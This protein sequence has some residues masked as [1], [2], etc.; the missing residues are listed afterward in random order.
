MAE[1]YRQDGKTEQALD[2]YN[3]AAKDKNYA[4]S[5]LQRMS[6]LYAL[7]KQP[8]AAVKAARRALQYDKSKEARKF[9]EQIKSFSER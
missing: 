6:R 4:A 3:R 1:L 2:F 7:N 5:S 9:Y 8:V